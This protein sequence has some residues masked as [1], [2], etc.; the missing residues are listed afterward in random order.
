[1][2][3]IYRVQAVLTHFLY[4]W[5]TARH[6]LPSSSSWVGLCNPPAA[7]R[8]YLQG[9]KVTFPVTTQEPA[10]RQRR[11]AIFPGQLLLSP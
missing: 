11:G 8:I 4:S 2:G 9:Q 3:F 5:S 6:L 7:S 10:Q 1:M